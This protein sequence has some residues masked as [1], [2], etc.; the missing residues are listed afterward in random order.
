M[1]TQSIYTITVSEPLNILDILNDFWT[2]AG[3]FLTFIYGIIVGIT[4]WLFKKIKKQA[5]QK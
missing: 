4:P 3:P 1:F 2:K 5:E